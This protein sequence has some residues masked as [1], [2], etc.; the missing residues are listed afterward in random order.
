MVS[1]QFMSR[2]NKWSRFLDS[3]VGWISVVSLFAVVLFFVVSLLA[4]IMIVPVYILNNDEGLYNAI[5]SGLVPV[6]IIILVS[7]I[8]KPLLKKPVREVLKLKKPNKKVWWMIPAVVGGYVLLL[9]LFFMILYAINPS[10]LEQ[11]QDV[12]LAIEKIKGLKLLFMVIGVAILT[13]IAEELFFR[14]L[15]LSL[16]A[17]KTKFLLGIF[18]GALLFG[19]AHWQLNV[20]VD[21]FLFGVALGLLTWQTESIYPAI[22]LHMFK[23]GL[24][25]TAILN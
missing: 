22:I 2:K 3:K 4:A 10:I 14:G 19:L 8:A 23:N 15:L 20:S 24:A 6:L 13:P 9:I 1:Y 18:V 11:K 16:Y 17:K 21:T 12:A 7:L 25:L 5:L